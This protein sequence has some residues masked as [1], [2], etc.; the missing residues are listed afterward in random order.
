M[1]D[2]HARGYRN[3][4]FIGGTSNRDTRGADRKLGYAQAIAELGLQ[5]PRGENQQHIEK[6]HGGFSF[7]LLFQFDKLSEL[8]ELCYSAKK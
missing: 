8:V 6:N 5:Q 4:G 1:H 7:L 3:I 2:L